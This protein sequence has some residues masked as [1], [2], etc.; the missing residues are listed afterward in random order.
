MSKFANAPIAVRLCV[1]TLLGFATS[2]AHAATLTVDV[3]GLKNTQGQ[4]IVC[5]WTQKDGFP[6]CQKSST[7]RRQTL[8]ISGKDLDVTF[9]DVTPGDYA[10]TVQHDEDGN[11][12]LKTN[13]IGMPKEGIGVS[14]NPSGIPRF[15]NAQVPV[16]SD[17]RITVQIRYL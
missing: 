2:A 16:S 11:G 13:F 1:A 6:T 4:L 3:Q 17:I 12:K 5:L 14:N 15:G 9:K 10:V 7:A 8:P